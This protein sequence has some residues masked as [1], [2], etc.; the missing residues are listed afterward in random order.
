MAVIVTCWHAETDCCH[1]SPAVFAV[2][3]KLARKPYVPAAVG[4]VKLPLKLPFPPVVVFTIV[5]K[6]S[7]PHPPSRSW[8][9]TVWPFGTGTLAD[10]CPEKAMLL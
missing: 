3:R 6:P 4:A 1:V 5:E 2:W 8:S 9:C 7:A 10:T